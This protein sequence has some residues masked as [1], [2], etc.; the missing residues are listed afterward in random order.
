[1]VEDREG[2]I[3]ECFAF[4]PAGVEKLVRA[5]QDR[6]LAD[7]TSLFAKVDAWHEAGRMVIDL[8]AVPGRK[9]RRAELSVS[10][11]EVESCA[12]RTARL[13]RGCPNPSP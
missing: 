12:P 2:D 9:A 4:N 1:M 10:F 6:R 11:G 13:P 5:A 3:Y 8:P 7:E